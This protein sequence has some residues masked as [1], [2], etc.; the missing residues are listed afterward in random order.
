M[1][2]AILIPVSAITYIFTP[3][4]IYLDNYLLIE[5]GLLLLGLILFLILFTLFINYIFKKEM[6]E[7]K[8]FLLICGGFFVLITT[9][10]FLGIFSILIHPIFNARYIFPIIGLLWLSFATLL[11]QYYSKKVV[12]IPILVI[13]L[14]IGIFNVVSFTNSEIQDNRAMLE[15]ESYLDQVKT[16]DTIIFIDWKFLSYSFQFYSKNYS[17]TL[18]QYYIPTIKDNYSL[19]YYYSKEQNFIPIEDISLNDIKNMLKK[20]KIWVLDMENP[21]FNP[22]ISKLM[23]SNFRIDGFN[24]TLNENGLYL[25]K[26]KKLT[27]SRS[28]YYP[29]TIY[30]IDYK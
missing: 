13:V 30:S 16:N 24:N 3:V 7:K 28:Y 20:G 9:I 12:F 8:S 26:F 17:F 11:S 23:I 14:T 27:N 15:F 10:M 18:N 22:Q 29:H 1:Q 25:N 4:N 19:S 6:Y 5:P 2:D 21:V